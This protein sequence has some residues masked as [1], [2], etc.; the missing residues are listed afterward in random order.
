MGD[1]ISEEWERLVKR[2][3]YVEREERGEE[4]ERERRDREERRKRASAYLA[5]SH[6]PR[7]SSRLEVL[8]ARQIA[9]LLFSFYAGLLIILVA[10]FSNWISHSLIHSDTH[11][12]D[13]FHSFSLSHPLSISRS[14]SFCFSLSVSLCLS[15][16]LSIPF[17]PSSSLSLFSLD[18]RHRHS[19]LRPRSGVVSLLSLRL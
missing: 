12:L 14:P 15:L 1:E 4:G 11:C 7:P 16:C 8:S 3:K 19:I 17:S 5:T 18:R 9:F 2:E 10:L 6:I 13:S